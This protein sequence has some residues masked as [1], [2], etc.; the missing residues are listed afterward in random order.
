MVILKV[1]KMEADILKMLK[2]EMGNPTIKSFLR[3]GYCELRVLSL[4][5]VFFFVTDDLQMH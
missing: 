1:V 5:F 2:F 4:S 3:Q